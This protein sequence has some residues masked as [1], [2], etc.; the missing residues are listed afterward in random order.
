MVP[1]LDPAHALG[2]ERCMLA[3]CY[4]PS[5]LSKVLVGFRSVSCMDISK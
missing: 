2:A 5:E 3:Q 4:D 1:K